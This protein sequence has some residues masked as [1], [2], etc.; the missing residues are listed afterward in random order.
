MF[1]RIFLLRLLH[2]TAAVADGWTRYFNVIS[3]I[4]FRSSPVGW[5]LCG[6]S[7]VEDFEIVLF[8]VGRERSDSERCAKRINALH[9]LFMP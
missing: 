2:F 5:L 3:Q 6:E 1:R 7:K 9:T 4:G 8:K